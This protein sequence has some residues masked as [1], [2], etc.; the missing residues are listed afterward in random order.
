[1]CAWLS[2]HYSSLTMN[3]SFSNWQQKIELRSE[4]RDHLP[5]FPFV[6]TKHVLICFDL[7]DCTNFKQT[8]CIVVKRWKTMRVNAYAEGTYDSICYEWWLFCWRISLITG[9]MLCFSAHQTHELCRCLPYRCH[10]NYAR[11][12]ARTLR[13]RSFIRVVLFGELFLLSLWDQCSNTT[14]IRFIFFSRTHTYTNVHHS[15]RLKFIARAEWESKKSCNS[16]KYITESYCLYAA[17]LA[18]MP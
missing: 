3:D 2:A 7:S 4:G 6:H 13:F 16:F 10:N 11:W 17:D 1:M 5:I 8:E 9:S 12:R 15:R 18:L 14:S